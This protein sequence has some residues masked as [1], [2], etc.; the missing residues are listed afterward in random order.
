MDPLEVVI[1]QLFM[2]INLWL[3]VILPILNGYLIYFDVRL[4][5]RVLVKISELAAHKDQ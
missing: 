2:D 4:L 3:N 5:R 1:N